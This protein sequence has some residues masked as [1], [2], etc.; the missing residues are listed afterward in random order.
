MFES[1]IGPGVRSDRFGTRSLITFALVFVPVW[2]IYFPVGLAA[3][4]WLPTLACALTT[5]GA[6]GCGLVGV[7]SRVNDQRRHAWRGLLKAALPTLAGGFV[8]LIFLALAYGNFTF[9]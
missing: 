4:A 2:A 7:F 5:L 9:E 1:G 3:L 8:L 6:L